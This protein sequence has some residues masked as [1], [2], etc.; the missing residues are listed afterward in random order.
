MAFAQVASVATAQS[1]QGVISTAARTAAAQSG[2][3][4]LAADAKTAA[5]VTS[6]SNALSLSGASSEVIADA[7]IQAVADGTISAGVALSVA[8]AVAPDMAAKIAA[9]PAVVAQLSRTGQSATV[10][11]S[12]NAAG[13]VSV[14]VG[15]TGAGGG[16]GTAAYD[17]CAGVIAAYCGG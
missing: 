10:T 5:I 2:F 16:G 17:P 11:A 12:T 13:G 14:L 6:V 7:L 8:A 3:Q 9:A 1:L 4:A 15:L